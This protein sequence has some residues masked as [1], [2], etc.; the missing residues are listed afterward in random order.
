MHLCNRS[1]KSRIKNKHIF[2]KLVNHKIFTFTEITTFTVAWNMI[3]PLRK[4]KHHLFLWNTC[5]N[6]YSVRG[7]L[8]ERKHLVS[9]KILTL[10]CQDKVFNSEE[11]KLLKIL[12]DQ[13]ELFELFL[14]MIS[15]NVS[16]LVMVFFLQH[17]PV[18][19]KHPSERQHWLMTLLRVYI[20]YFKTRKHV[21][22]MNYVQSINENVRGRGSS[23]MN[24]HHLKKKY[25]LKKASSKQARNVID[26]NVSCVLRSIS[27]K[28][29]QVFI[30]A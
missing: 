13:A 10:V 11:K 1:L 19:Y 9:L 12:P 15:S 16:S 17:F 29:T 14:L 7:I 26:H 21:T 2:S 30:S 23:S 20:I 5:K 22:S 25:S 3:Q 24:V 18:Y 28:K 4:L 27:S 6:P 8:R